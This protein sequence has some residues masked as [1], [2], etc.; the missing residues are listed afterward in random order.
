METKKRVLEHRVNMTAK[1]VDVHTPIKYESFHLLF[2]H[3]QRQINVVLSTDQNEAQL[4]SVIG[5]T[6]ILD[7][8]FV[9]IDREKRTAEIVQKPL[10]EY[11]NKYLANLN[12]SKRCYALINGNVVEGKF[13]KSII[14]AADQI[15]QITDEIQ[16]FLDEC[17]PA[18]N[19]N[20]D[21]LDKYDGALNMSSN[22]I[23][24]NE[25]ALY[26]TQYFTHP[27]YG[28]V[29]V[30]YW[31]ADIIATICTTRKFT[32]SNS[33]LAQYFP[34]SDEEDDC[35]YVPQIYA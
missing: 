16:S 32:S 26:S 30:G 4:H 24:C 12:D 8:L 21:P 27:Q 18:N 13:A 17:T 20:D 9:R 2:P 15:Y 19:T 7:S 5:Y 3:R 25:S 33:T 6:N 1:S 14:I 28:S 35:Y 11:F 22:Y 34:K 23:I 31:G 10:K 29:K